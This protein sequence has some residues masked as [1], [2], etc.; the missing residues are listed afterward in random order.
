MDPNKAFEKSDNTSQSVAN[1]LHPSEPLV[2]KSDEETYKKM[3][4]FLEYLQKANVQEGDKRKNEKDA[5]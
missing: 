4:A 1:N 2:S 3:M 5:K